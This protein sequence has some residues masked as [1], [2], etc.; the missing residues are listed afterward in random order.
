MP[1]AFG[2]APL[3]GKVKN[4]KL[5]FIEHFKIDFIDLISEVDVIET[6]NYKDDYIDDKVTIW[7]NIIAELDKLSNL[8]KVCLTRKSFGGIP[9]MKKKI[10]EIKVYYEQRKIPFQSLITP[11]RIYSEDKQREWTNFFTTS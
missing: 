9:N 10:N 6:L 3:K 5:K 1:I 7:R 2:E 4:D 11:A 8:K